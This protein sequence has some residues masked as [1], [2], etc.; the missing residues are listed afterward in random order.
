MSKHFNNAP[1]QRFKTLLFSRQP[2]DPENPLG[3]HRE[4]SAR[5]VF[6]DEVCNFCSES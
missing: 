2:R 3:N 1:W 5:V 6:D 4:E